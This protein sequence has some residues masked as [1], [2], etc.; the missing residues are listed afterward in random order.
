MRKCVH[1][2]VVVMDSVF[3]GGQCVGT[4]ATANSDK[5]RAEE[6]IRRKEQQIEEMRQ[7]VGL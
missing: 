6:T 7:Q 3:G 2:H 1:I 5:T 4:T